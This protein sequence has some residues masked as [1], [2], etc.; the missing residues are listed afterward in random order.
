MTDICA[1]VVCVLDIKLLP[2]THLDVNEPTNNAF[3]GQYLL[4][5]IA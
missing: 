2:M 1:C 4:N 3:Y 5:F